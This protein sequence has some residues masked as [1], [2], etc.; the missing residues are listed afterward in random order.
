M[1]TS[2]EVSHPVLIN[3][4]FYAVRLTDVGEIHTTMKS[5]SD[6]KVDR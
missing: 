6:G 5:P 2:E 4:V 3:S 1:L